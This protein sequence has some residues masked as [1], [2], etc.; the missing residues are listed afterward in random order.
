M[1]ADEIVSIARQ[2]RC[3]PAENALSFARMVAQ[4]CA[5]LA[6]ECPP[7]STASD[8]ALAIRTAFKLHDA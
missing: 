8:A 4:Q 3:D 5:E 7:G 6:D 2:L 1:K